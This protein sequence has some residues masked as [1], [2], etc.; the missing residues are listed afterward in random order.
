[1]K[2]SSGTVKNISLELRG[3]AS[4][5]VI[6]D[7]DLSEALEGLINAKFRNSGQTCI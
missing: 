4:F 2:N 3:N 1:M 7:A 5:I 6:D